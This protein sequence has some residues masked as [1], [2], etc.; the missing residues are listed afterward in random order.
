MHT[1]RFQVKNVRMWI[2]FLVGTLPIFQ[3]LAQTKRPI[4]QDGS[5][6]VVVMPADTALAVGGEVS[7]KAFLVDPTG[8][9]K[10]ANFLWSFAGRPVGILTPQGHFKALTE[11]KGMV[12]ATTGRISG[13]AQ[14]TVRGGT[15]PLHGYRV[16][17]TPRDTVLKTGDTALFQA[18]LLDTAGKPVQAAF[19]WQVIDPRIGKIDGQGKFTALG[20]GQTFVLAKTG[21][22]IGKSNVVVLRDSIDWWRQHLRYEVVVT[23]RDTSVRIG[24][25]VQY[26]AV[27]FDSA[28]KPVAATFKWSLEEGGFGSLD[29]NGLFTALAKGQ[30]VVFAASG[31]FAGKA[32][33]TVIPDSGSGWSGDFW[34]TRLII[35]PR[36]TLVAIGSTVQYAA[37]LVDAA[38]AKK[39]VPVRWSLTGGRVGTISPEGLFKASARGMAVVV[40]KA[41]GRY[42]AAARVMVTLPQDLT[43]RDSVHVRFKDKGEHTVGNIHELGDS[44][45]FKISGLPF[46]LNFL[47]GGELV[48]PP[49]SVGSNVFIDITLPDLA[50][51]KNDTTVDFLK[52]VLTG[53]RFHVTVAGKLVSPF[54]FKEPVQ[55]VLPYKKELLNKLGLTPEKLWAFFY[56]ATGRL[57]SSGISS[58][59]V[60]TTE[61]KIYITVSHFS[62][63][64]V[65]NKSLASPTG[66][67]SRDGLP[68]EFRL[69]ENYPNP[70]N[71]ETQIRFDVAGR[72]LQK[73][74]LSVY[75]ILGREIRVL[76]DRQFAP[77][78]HEIRW[79]GKD[80]FGTVQNSGVYILRM[81]SAEV[82]LSQRMVMMK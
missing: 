43:R 58:V 1:N 17:I 72:G 47:N 48:F 27:L 13:K 36:D 78:S 2:V 79:D 56:T 28:R 50:Q 77:G 10:Q 3:V 70:F 59:V 76:A 81:V 52:G 7:Y 69:Y 64:V 80:S 51:I 60:D 82:T 33:V 35:Q 31:A 37:Y 21:E 20:W 44:D 54:V 9:R 4:E 49:G 34:K 14:V 74:K 16:V 73:V 66:V 18:M 41:D 71:P 32:H 25:K 22:H 45:V 46:P 68:G 23:P 6:R 42:S 53:A 38:G 29:E 65:A 57:D 11:G 19:A 8:A 5:Y 15:T 75:D 39:T 12:L 40:A 24:A 26:R 30:G 55:V 63:I 62:D 61:N 67:E